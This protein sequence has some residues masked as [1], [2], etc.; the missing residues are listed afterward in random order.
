MSLTFGLLLLA[1]SLLAQ[2]F[3]SGSEMAMVSSNREKLSAEAANGRASARLALELLDRQERLVGTCL[4]GTNLCLVTSG[5]LV[6]YLLRSRGY[7]AT[8][9]ATL[10]LTPL[11]LTFGEALLTASNWERVFEMVAYSICS[12]GQ[13]SGFVHAVDPFFGSKLV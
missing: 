2:G 3:F 10:A 1:A 7:D 13:F 6:A 12:A 11:A 4:I 8:A 5:T 9:L